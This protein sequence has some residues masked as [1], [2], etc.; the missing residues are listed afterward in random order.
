MKGKGGLVT[1]I[2]FSGI[3]HLLATAGRAA[4]TSYQFEDALVLC[5]LAWVVPSL[6]L[7]WIPETLLV[8]IF[9]AFWPTWIET[10]RLLVLPVAWQIL[11]VAIGLRET[12]QVGWPRGIGIGLVT[13][14][15]FFVSFLAYMR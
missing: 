11:L 9:G 1:W 7:M 10:L 8:P 2:A 13:V 5:G 6:V 12:H 3:A 4:P 15:V 14:L